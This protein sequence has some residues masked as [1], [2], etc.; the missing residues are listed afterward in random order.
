M[1]PRTLVFVLPIHTEAELDQFQRILDA[2]E[3]LVCADFSFSILFT[4]TL[5][6]VPRTSLPHEVHTWV[7]DPSLGTQTNVSLEWASVARHI[8]DRLDCLC[9]FWWEADVV[10]LRPDCFSFFLDRWEPGTKA[11]GYWVQDNLWNMRHRINGVGFYSRDFL[12]TVDASLIRPGLN[13]DHL[14]AYSP[15]DVQRG[16]LIPLNDAYCLTHH[17]GRVNLSA[18]TRL[19]HGGLSRE[20]LSELLSGTLAARLVSER[21]RRYLANAKIAELRVREWSEAARA[22]LQARL[23]ADP[24]QLNTSETST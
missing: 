18:Q 8:R 17:E 7:D 2:W 16:T 19:M 24:G 14:R 3:Q 10:P 5:P 21:E 20:V 4:T 12:D 9:W 1:L 6:R 23:P 13:F 22:W 11:M 15:A